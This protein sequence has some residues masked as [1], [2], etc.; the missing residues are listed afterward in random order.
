MHAISCTSLATTAGQAFDALQFIFHFFLAY[1]FFYDYE[2][3]I[4]F[5]FEFL[6]NC[7]SPI[8]SLLK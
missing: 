5:G 7:K 1:L 8:A 3:N 6:P 2:L 4:S